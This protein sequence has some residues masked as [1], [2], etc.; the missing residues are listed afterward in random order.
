MNIRAKFQCNAKMPTYGEDVVIH[1]N[2]VYSADPASENKV[3]T[4]AT[5]SAYL[6]MQ[7]SKG[8]VAAEQFEIG[9]QYYVDF[10]PA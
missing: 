5:P 6:Q 9:K 7:I 10:S 1:M 8:K 4:D 2:A 3:F